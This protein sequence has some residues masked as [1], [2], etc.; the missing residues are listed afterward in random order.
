MLLLNCQ[1]ISMN[2]LKDGFFLVEWMIQFLLLITISIIS[3]S[4]I[5]SWHRSIARMNCLS[6][7]LLPLYIATDLIRSDMHQAKEGGVRIE[8]DQLHLS[9]DHKYITWYCK[10][11]KLLRAA[12]SYD[13]KQQRW[14]KPVQSLIASHI[15]SGQWTLSELS[16]NG[17]QQSTITLIKEQESATDRKSKQIK[18]IVI[19]RNGL[20]I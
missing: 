7:E 1:D 16:A 11:H 6:T 3:Y 8:D 20:L 18:M 2:Q 15:Q 17:S 14:L 9:Y 5:V 4:L 12:G 13:Q 10:E 19:L